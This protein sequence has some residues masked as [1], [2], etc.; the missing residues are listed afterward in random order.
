MN[1]IQISFLTILSAFYITYLAKMMLLRSQGIT[2]NLLGKGNKNKKAL[3]IELFLR[4][5][6]FIGAVIQYASVI[7]QKAVWSIP[8]N[9]TIQTIGFVL[10]FI[11]VVFFIL[12]VVT[13]RNNWRAGFSSEQKTN[14]VTGGIYRI[15]RN[16]AFVGFDLLYIGCALAFPNIV[17]S[18]AAVMSVILFHI[19]ILG[20]EGYLASAFG[21]EY[22]KY[23]IKVNRYW[24][25]KP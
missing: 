1:T 5:V 13:M 6:T 17:N 3:I 12:A 7:F 9:L 11:G 21:Q 22:E 19:Q 10:T 24:G 8:I 16:P 25:R 15:S 4:A 23:Q 20:E 14:L 18:A 2:G